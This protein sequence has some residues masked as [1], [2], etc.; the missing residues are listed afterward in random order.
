MYT[1]PEL[2][3]IKERGSFA[4]DLLMSLFRGAVFD[5]G[6]GAPKNNRP[7][8]LHEDPDLLKY[9]SLRSCLQML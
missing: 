9:R 5:H 2:G 4:I 3:I 7:I 1:T 8:S 6:R